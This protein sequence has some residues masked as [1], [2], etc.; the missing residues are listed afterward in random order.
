[1]SIA[2]EIDECL[3]LAGEHHGT[4]HDGLPTAEHDRLRFVDLFG[5]KDVRHLEANPEVDTFFPVEHVAEGAGQFNVE[6]I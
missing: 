1:M 2:S 5:G 3:E 6:I 4:W